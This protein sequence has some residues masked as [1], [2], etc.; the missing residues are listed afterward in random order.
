MRKQG[1]KLKDKSTLSKGEYLFDHFLYGLILGSFD[2]YNILPYFVPIAKYNNSIPRLIICMLLTSMFG[3][4][5]SYN[6]N[7]CG[8]GVIQDIIS[9]V[10]LYTVSTLGE[11]AVGFISWLCIGLLVISVFGII[12]IITKNVKRKDRIN[13][14]MFSRFLRCTQVVRRNVGVAAVIAVV[15]LPIGLNCF[16]NEKLNED[17]YEKVCEEYGLNADDI[18]DGI[19][20]YEGELS[21]L[22]N[23]GD[24][25]RLEKNI[26]TIKLIRDN[27]TFQ[28]L[29][30]EKK[31]DVLRAVCY[32]EARYLG[33]C[34]INIVFEDIE[35]D[36]LL[37]TY[38][39]AT[40]TITVNAKPIKDGSSPGGTAEELLITVLHEC[41][42]CY[43]NLLSEMYISA[44]PEQ[45]NLLAFTGEG[46]N[47]W[48]TNIG[49]YKPGDETIEG[50]MEYYE[51]PIER[52]ARIY[53]ETAAQIYYLMIDSL[54]NKQTDD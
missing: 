29:D 32:C 30:Y 21:V 34:K 41:R 38:N 23:Y 22:E 13:Q 8:K 37:G 10:G 19:S 25:Y 43:Q 2:V 12:L 7:R 15:A 51:Q 26:D 54:L 16:Q 5:I 46:V 44:T 48:I 6:H 35:D 27:D 1:I 40:K 9:G 50:Q 20:G 47:G 11:Y 52:D 49:D 31:C 42:H 28:T 53:A 14:I 45:R 39:H 3:I 24:E 36:T 4:V 33:L 18:Q 17:Y